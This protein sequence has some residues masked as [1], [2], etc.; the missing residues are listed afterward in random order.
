MSTRTQATAGESARSCTA[1]RR[2]SQSQLS[3]ISALQS[4]QW[5]PFQRADAQVLA[6]LHKQASQQNK[7]SDVEDALL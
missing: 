5:W 7:V 4:G 6:Y 1:S 2:W 3:E